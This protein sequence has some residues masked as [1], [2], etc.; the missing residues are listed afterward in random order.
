MNNRESRLWIAALSS[1][2]LLLL[3]LRRRSTILQ[4]LP[5]FVEEQ[6]VLPI[7]GLL[8]DGVSGRDEGA[9]SGEERM[10]RKVGRNRKISVHGKL[11]GPLD[12][13]YIGRQVE[14]EERDG[15]V[16]VYSESVEIGS[17][18]QEA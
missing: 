11:Y 3:V 16:V 9:E 1:A 13:Q 7:S 14:V 15:Q 6:I 10:T 17:F 12:P 4:S 18:E 2:V 8:R 5:E